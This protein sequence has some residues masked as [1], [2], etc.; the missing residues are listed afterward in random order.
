VVVQTSRLV[1]SAQLVSLPAGAAALA[2]EGAARRLAGQD[3]EVVAAD[4]RSRNAARTQ[5]VL[6]G[7]KGGAL[8][9]GQLL[10]TVEALFPQDP[11]STWRDTLVGLQ[12]S[13]EALPFAEVEPVCAPSWARTGARRSPPS[14][15]R[16][17][18]PRRSARCTGDLGRRPSRRGQGAVPRCPRG[19]RR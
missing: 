7:L 2:V 12:D 9:A 1:R 8:K 10:S 17:R 6:G 4:L 13:N 15:S 11:E 16:R 18:R 14:R 19:A 3:R 5:R